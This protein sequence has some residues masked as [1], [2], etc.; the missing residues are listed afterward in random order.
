MLKVCLVVDVEGFISLKQINPMWNSWQ[1][2]K[3]KI[4]YLFRNLRYDKK[5]FEKIYALC[6][7][8]NFPSTFML[9]GEFKPLGKEKFIDWGYHTLSHKPLTLVN[10]KELQKEVKN[11]FNSASF[12]A[13]IGLIHDIKNPGRVF[14]ALRKEGYKIAPYRGTMDGIKV[15]NK[16]V[17][18]IE[19]PID[20]YGIKC[21]YVSSYLLDNAKNWKEIIKEVKENEDKDAV[22]CISAHDFNQKNIENFESMIKEL[23]KMEKEKIIEPRNFKQLII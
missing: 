10:D 18:G 17:S 20:L 23:K 4:N 21:V 19:K 22:Y 8:Y 9:T 7:K 5:G 16:K 6:V 14:I 3:G 13:P 2:I 12:S 15:A 11:I 1:K